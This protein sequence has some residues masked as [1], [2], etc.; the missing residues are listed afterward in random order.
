[1]RV[2]LEEQLSAA[3][4]VIV[5][6]V[7]PWEAMWNRSVDLFISLQ[8]CQDGRLEQRLFEIYGRR[9]V[10]I[11]WHE[12]TAHE[13]QLK[14]VRAAMQLFKANAR[15]PYSLVAITRHDL[16]FERRID[17]WPADWS[18]FN[19]A[20][21]CDARRSLTACMN[22]VFISL[23]TTLFG[24]FD[25]VIG[26]DKCFGPLH[27]GCHYCAP[28]LGPLIGGDRAFGSLWS[29][30]PKH[31]VQEDSEY[32]RWIPRRLSTTPNRKRHVNGSA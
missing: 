21:R 29:W 10:A 6:I 26:T 24:A 20:S 30:V 4:S 28:T 17:A 31:S 3:R 32:A 22:D 14:S 25:S 15:R 1:M 19:F 12:P 5:N 11:G 8:H 7:R 13:G 16:H 9:V 18:L 23:P 27:P 2:A